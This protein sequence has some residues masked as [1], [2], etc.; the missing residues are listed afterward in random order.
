VDVDPVVRE[1]VLA[2]DHERHGQEVAVAQAL[3]GALDDARRGGAGE[4][5]RRAQGQGGD[6]LAGLDALA[7]GLERHDAAV[8]DLE[9]RDRR[10]EP[11]LAAVGDDLVGHRL[12]H[13]AGAEAGVVELV[14]ERLD[15]VALV[16]HEGGLGGRPERQALD[17]LRGPLGADLGG[18]DAPDLLGVGLEEEV[19]QPLAEAVRDP[20]LEVLLAPLGLHERPQVREAGAHELDGAEL[21][22]HVRAAE[23]VVEEL[24]VPVDARHARALEE[25]LAHDFVPEVVDLLG[26][27]E[28]AVAAEVE[29]VAV[30]DLG[31]RQAADLALGL[32]HDH[33]LAL[34][35]E[36]VAGGQ[37]RRASTEDGNRALALA[38]RP[39][40]A[41]RVELNGGHACHDY[42]SRTR[43]RRGPNGR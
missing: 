16:A 4:A 10:V 42:P 8:A 23:R 41:R 12:P 3:R 28:E 21:L 22:D 39:R 20:L 6:H 32:E 30:A 13:L 34:L 5:D 19:E 2:V 35:R 24:A 7:A 18:R 33:G 17:P 27:R 11:H 9:L 15:L 40:D 25:L 29:A 38:V 14:D 1:Q 31:L 36:Q 43:H 37:A 26:L